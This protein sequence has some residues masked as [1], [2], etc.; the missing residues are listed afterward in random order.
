M[1]LSKNKKIFFASD[2]HFG[3]PTLEASKKREK[4]FI[5]WLEAIAPQAQAL[6]LLGDLFDFWVEYK[7]VVPKGHVRI[8]GKLA[9]LVDAGLHIEYFVGNHDLWM[10]G[11]FEEEL[12]I[13]V[14]HQPQEMQWNNTTFLVGHGDGLGPGDWGYKQMKKVF[15]NPLAQA[16][17]RAIPSRWGISLGQYLSLKNKLISGQEAP[18]FLGEKKEW[19]VQYC[20]EKQQEKQRDYYIFGHRHLPLNIPLT[21]GANYLNLGDWLSHNTYAVFDGTTTE[22]KTWTSPND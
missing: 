11:Y 1:E 6:Y 3:A 14:H 15:T 10:K 19:L 13:S 4:Y 5:A 9:Q 2:Q 17:F 7:K 18:Q 20:L 12:G 16:L 8:L 21:Q 22:L